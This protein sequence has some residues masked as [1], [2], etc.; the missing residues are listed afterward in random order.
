MYRKQQAH[1]C[2]ENSPKRS[3]TAREM[4]KF[5]L[6]RWRQMVRCGFLVPADSRFLRRPGLQRQARQ[7]EQAGPDYHP[8]GQGD[9]GKK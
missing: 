6:G 5:E 1:L 2:Q 8:D 4:R 7:A 9:T 3:A